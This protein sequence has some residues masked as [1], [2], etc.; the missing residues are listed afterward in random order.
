M[1]PEIRRSVKSMTEYVVRFSELK[2]DRET[3]EFLLEDSFFKVFQSADW[4]GGSV[5]AVVEVNKRPDGITLDF[6]LKGTLLVACDRC[7]DTFPLQIRFADKLFVK[8]GQEE[9]ELDDNVVVISRDENQIDLS[10]F[11]YEYVVLAIPVTKVHPN[12]DNESSACNPEMIEKLKK[13]VISE[14]S[15]ERDE[16]IDPRWDD[17]KKLFD[18]N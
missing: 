13:Y 9:D 5:K 18:K 11:L 17:L 16:Y 14:E 2:E 8:Y 7:L 12:R 15:E 10:Q 1:Q 4:E 3:F 6:E